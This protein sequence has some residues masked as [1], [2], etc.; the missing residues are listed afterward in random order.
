MPNYTRPRN[1]TNGDSTEASDQMDSLEKKKAQRYLYLQRL[2]DLTNGDSF[3]DVSM[4]HM[5]ESLGWDQETFNQVETYLEN[6]ELI[7]H[8]AFGMVSISHRGVKQIESALS[9][10]GEASTYFP[11]INILV[12]QADVAVLIDA[13]LEQVLHQPRQPSEQKTA[14]SNKVKVEDNTVVIRIGGLV[15]GDHLEAIRSTET[16]IL[17]CRDLLALRQMQ[18]GTMAGFLS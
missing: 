16:T 11:P 6:E 2:Y 14:M 8:Q 9:H 5:R 15:A 1:A 4:Q 13:Y 7:T 18:R 10:P 3:A 12:I 17:L